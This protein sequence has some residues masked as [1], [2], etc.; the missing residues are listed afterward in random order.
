MRPTGSLV[1]VYF[2]VGFTLA[3]ALTM[4]ALTMLRPL[5]LANL[6]EGARRLAML[7]PAV[8]GVFFG[9]RV[10]MMGHTRGLRLGQAL[11]AALGLRRG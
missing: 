2:G 6:G 7:T 3:A 8:V 10:A 4:V 9:A 11:V 5:I 1:V